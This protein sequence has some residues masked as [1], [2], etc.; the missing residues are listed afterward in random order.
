MPRYFATSLWEEFVL[1]F[2]ELV[3]ITSSI[4]ETMSPDDDISIAR[5]SELLELVT[6]CIVCVAQVG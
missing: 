6:S 3:R 2:K 4:R 5:Y 1:L